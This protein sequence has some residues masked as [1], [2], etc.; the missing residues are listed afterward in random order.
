[1]KT[2]FT[3]KIEELRDLMI[4]EIQEH[5]SS[6]NLVRVKPYDSVACREDSYNHITAY[7]AEYIH[8]SSVWSNVSYKDFSVEELDAVVMGL[9]PSTYKVIDKIRPEQDECKHPS[10]RIRE[11]IAGG[12]FDEC[13]DCG[14]TWG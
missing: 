9:N 3:D 1:M 11:N 12:R 2:K 6:N 7:G 13:L 5:F 10:D 14:K 4:K 8:Q